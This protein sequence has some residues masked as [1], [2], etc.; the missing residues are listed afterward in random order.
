M[1]FRS[2]PSLRGIVVA[3]GARTVIRL[4]QE[5]PKLTA[6]V[7]HVNVRAGRVVAAVFDSEMA[8]YVP[9]GADWI[10]A[11]ADPA[12]RQLIPGIIPGPG[13]RQLVIHAPGTTDATV[14][15]RLITRSGAY[16]PSALSQ[17]DVPAGGVV[18]VDLSKAT[19]GQAVTLDLRSDQPIVA[20]VRQWHPGI[21]ATADATEEESYAAAAVPF[22]DVAAASGLPAQRSTGETLW[23][24]SAA[25]TNPDDT[26]IAKDD[27]VSATITLLPDNG[28]ATV[29]KTV[30]VPAN[31]VVEVYLQRPANST[32]FTAIVQASGGSLV[33]AHRVVVRNSA[34][35]LISGFPWRPLRTTVKVPSARVD[36][37]ISLPNP[38]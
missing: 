7:W 17:V 23:L 22:Q 21:D 33:A 18:A 25:L 19:D 1:L 9:R 2:T 11:A 16:V 36:A 27:S 32:W 5:A 3:P 15:V 28:A 6:A 37:G 24:T 34:G 35:S 20:G 12:T 30:Q 26:A 13:D 10:P 8:G 14:Q 31:R 29:L 4:S 38:G